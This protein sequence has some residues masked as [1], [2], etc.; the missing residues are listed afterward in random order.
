MPNKNESLIQNLSNDISKDTGNIQETELSAVFSKFNKTL[1][2]AMKNF[3]SQSFDD[4][5]FIKKLKEVDFGE[6]K[7]KDVVKNVL[8]SVKNEYV[9]ATTLNHSEVLLRRDLFNVCSQMPELRDVIYIIRDAI[10]ESNVATGEVSRSITFDNHEDTE[11]YESQCKEVEKKFNTLMGIKNFLIP[12]T[13]MIGETC[14]HVVPYAKL[15]AE[16]DAVSHNNMKKTKFRE[17]IPNNIRSYFK[18]TKSLY[19]DENLKMLM[20]SV[21]IP[22]KVDTNDDYKIH[23]NR[24]ESVVDKDISK[25]NLKALLDNIEVANG[26]SL[27]M[28]EM[29]EDGFKEFLYREYKE[30]NDSIKNSNSHFSEGFDFSRTSSDIFGKQEEEDIDYKSYENVKGCYV[31]YLDPLRLIPIRLDRRVIG[32]YYV[33]TTMDLQVNPAQPTG[34]VDLSFQHYTRDKNLV[35][36]LTSILIQ[37]FDKQML[38][39]NVNFKN[40]IA[41][42]IMAHR[43]SEGRLS[44]IFIPESEVVR[45]VVN[46]DENGK[47]H[48]T[49]EPC[50]FNARNYLM[51]TL[52]NMLYVL[53]NNMTRI[54]YLKSSGLDKNYAAQIQR[55]IRKFQ[56]RR[57]TIDDIYSYSGVLNKVGG[58]GEMILPAGRGDYKAIETDTLE[59]ANNPINPEFLEQQRRQSI[60][61]SGVPYLM[62]TNMID[63]V[64]FAK[65]ME[66]ANARFLSTISSYKIDFANG[67]TEFYKK[68]LKY[69]T[70][71]ED[72]IIQSFH[73]VFNSSKQQ[74][75]NITN[76]MISNF[77]TLVDTV[78]S[79]YFN[80]SELAGEN[81]KPSPIMKHLRRELAKDY[82]PQL[83]FEELESVVD[84]VKLAAI[85][86]RLEDKIA[87]AKLTDDDVEEIV[88][89]S[90]E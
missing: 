11:A 53:N 65:T 28:V 30:Y 14:I 19:S 57:I 35:D 21:S 63:E 73:F 85:D 42:I 33:T 31:K 70:D 1:E 37:S 83:D 51:L 18:E 12:K 10:I 34:I 46:E 44:F 4:S 7:S 82:L 56:S 45:I 23:N 32:Y 40:E 8:N 54:H 86:D 74:D 52:Y 76:D 71:L 16:L 2:K 67:I 81:D 38:N 17:S 3:N 43:F 39:K 36:R 29:G 61:G 89:K 68:L 64:D 87:N 88:N 25:L 60:S 47:G 26:S 72:P 24:T 66:M 80:P 5:G 77:N 41:E 79:M 49:I 48:S 22:A 20:E 78:A 90:K 15:F 75:L 55:T 6:R 62:S 9:D 27:C 69:N 58:R 84:R 59:P 13:L 50:L